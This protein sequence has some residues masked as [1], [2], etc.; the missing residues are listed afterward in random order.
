M[1]NKRIK[2]G[3]NVDHVATL[4]EARKIDFPDPKQAAILAEKAGCDSIV[5]HLREDRRHIK[6]KDIQNIKDSI[7][8]KLNLEMSTMPDIVDFALEVLPDQVT[9][10]PEREQ[11]ITT[12]GGL[13]LENQVEHITKII[14]KFKAKNIQTSL[15]IDPSEKQVNYASMTKADFIEFHTGQYV[16][17]KSFKSRE[18]Q[19]NKLVEC[20]Q[21]ANSLG[22]GVNAGH[23]LNYDNVVSITKLPYLEELNIGHSIIAKAIFVGIEQAVK[24][25][26]NLLHS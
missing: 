1:N 21:L 17:A 3:I 23:G 7:Q 12:E 14:E 13:D 15:F 22:L 10:V 11:E 8:V 2:L 16:D 5:V 26:L 25:M 20:A 24:Q 4:R 9:L 19:L 6:E 18:L